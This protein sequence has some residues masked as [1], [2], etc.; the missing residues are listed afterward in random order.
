MPQ[1]PS[2]A[3]G[4]GGVF[5]VLAAVDLNHEPFLSTNKVNNIRPDRLLTHKLES[6]KRP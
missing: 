2:I 4:I 1:K 5:G 3:R 6:S